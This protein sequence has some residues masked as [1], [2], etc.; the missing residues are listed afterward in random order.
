MAKDVY[1]SFSND[2]KLGE[3]RKSGLQV[4]LSDGALS[5]HL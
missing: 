5:K 4:W 3:T 1:V 2:N